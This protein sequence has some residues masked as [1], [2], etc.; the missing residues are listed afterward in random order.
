MFTILIWCPHITEKVCN[1][2]LN[3]YSLL[4]IMKQFEYFSDVY[5]NW[6]G[7]LGMIALILLLFT[8]KKAALSLTLPNK[9][10]SVEREIE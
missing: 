4:I 9:V 5:Q 2:C 6:L 1:D 3:K 10:I 7:V 8:D